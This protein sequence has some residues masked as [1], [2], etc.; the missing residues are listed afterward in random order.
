MIFISEL[1]ICAGE[2]YSFFN[3]N[4]M[5]TYVCMYV[6]CQLPGDGAGVDLVH[7]HL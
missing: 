6:E 2:A 7:A 3:F 4:R 1:H 5:N